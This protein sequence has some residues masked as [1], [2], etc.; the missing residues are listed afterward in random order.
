MLT[1]GRQAYEYHAAFG[2]AIIYWRFM[3]SGRKNPSVGRCN[4]VYFQSEG[5]EA[6]MLQA[7][8]K[9]SA[10]ADTESPTWTY[11]WLAPGSPLRRSE[12]WGPHLTRYCGVLTTQWLKRPHIHERVL[13]NDYMRK[14]IGSLEGCRFPIQGNKIRNMS[15]DSLNKWEWVSQTFQF[16][17][18]AQRT[19]CR[20]KIAL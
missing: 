16:Q 10:P 9:N 2:V 3:L 12:D 7:Y 13:H 8:S 20:G 15:P 1:L 4:L 5:L 11:H 17:K 14:L 19:T 6:K 18:T